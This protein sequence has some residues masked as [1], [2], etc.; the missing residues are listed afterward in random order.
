MAFQRH[1]AKCLCRHPPGQLVLSENDLG[2]FR[3]GGRQWTVPQRLYIQSLH[4]VARLFLD[5]NQINDQNHID[6]FVYYI[7]CRRD[8]MLS[9]L[10][11]NDHV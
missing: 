11:V 9:P 7:L 3:I 1:A 4:R 2:I 5:E 6:E 10:Q 8:P